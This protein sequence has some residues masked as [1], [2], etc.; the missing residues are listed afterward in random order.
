MKNE[1]S[2]F[3]D[4]NFSFITFPR[5]VF[6]RIFHIKK[7]KEERLSCQDFFLHSSIILYV[8]FFQNYFKKGYLQQNKK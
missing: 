5:Q 7:P 3:T 6:V 2:T 1:E 4:F 8:S